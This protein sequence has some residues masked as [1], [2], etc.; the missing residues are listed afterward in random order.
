MIKL[1]RLKHS[2]YCA[3]ESSTSASSILDTAAEASSTTKSPLLPAGA[4]GFL[5]NPHQ[6][7]LFNP[8]RVFVPHLGANR[9][10]AFLSEA[11]RLELLCFFLKVV[12][13]SV[14]YRYA[15]VLLSAGLCNPLGFLQACFLVENQDACLVFPGQAVGSF[16]G[17]VS[18]VFKS[19]NSSTSFA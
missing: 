7:G 14:G 19:F 15:E 10:P 1:S 12:F 18:A 8:R 13:E 5:L 16:Q 17:L 11:C 3:L 4:S 6:E 9:H 2:G